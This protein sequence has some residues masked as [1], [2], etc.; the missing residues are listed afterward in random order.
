MNEE[1]IAVQSAMAKEAQTCFVASEIDALNVV[2]RV[3]LEV[4]NDL[5][6][7]STNLSPRHD[8]RYALETVMSGLECFMTFTNAY[9]KLLGAQKSQVDWANISDVDDAIFEWRRRF[10][11]ATGF[12]EKCRRLADLY[13]LQLALVAMRYG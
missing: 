3:V 6:D 9:D 2:I 12:V 13:K 5:A 8:L 4:S 10:I 7:Q 1:I 11:A